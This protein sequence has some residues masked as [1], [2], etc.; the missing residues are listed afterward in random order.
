MKHKF[1][2]QNGQ[3]VLHK[4]LPLASALRPFVTLFAF[5]FQ[6]K[7]IRHMI[8]FTIHRAVIRLMSSVL[9]LPSHGV[10]FPKSGLKY[11]CSISGK[12]TQSKRQNQEIIDF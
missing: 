9:L 11:S 3:E 10:H 1:L 12:A 8:G 2:V 7:Y 4:I 6:T 5:F